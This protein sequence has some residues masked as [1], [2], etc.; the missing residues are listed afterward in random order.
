MRKVNITG[1]LG[2]NN[3]RVRNNNNRINLHC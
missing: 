1:V 3:E 2:K